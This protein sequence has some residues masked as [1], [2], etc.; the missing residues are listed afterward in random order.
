MLKC[1]LFEENVSPLS[2]HDAPIKF[3]K[4]P[5]RGKVFFLVTR[6]PKMIVRYLLS[7]LVKNGE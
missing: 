6:Y 4:I 2:F 5:L 3:F 7:P 1:F